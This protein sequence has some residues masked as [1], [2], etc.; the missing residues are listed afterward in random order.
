[1]VEVIKSV[2]EQ[3][4]FNIDMRVGKWLFFEIIRCLEK[5]FFVELAK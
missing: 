3:T 5:C 2:R 1:M 4:K